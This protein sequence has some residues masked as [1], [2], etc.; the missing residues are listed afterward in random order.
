MRCDDGCCLSLARI[1]RRDDRKSA[2]NK[3]QNLFWTGGASTY[4]CHRFL[5][6]HRHRPIPSAARVEQLLGN[7]CPCQV[8]IEWF[9]HTSWLKSVDVTSFNVF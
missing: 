8:E 2:A 3:A 5:I 7:F 6:V 4:R 9:D 1:F